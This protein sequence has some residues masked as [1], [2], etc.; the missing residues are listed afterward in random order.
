MS[1]PIDTPA[2]IKTCREIL[3][4]EKAGGMW[5][6]NSSLLEGAIDRLEEMYKEKYPAEPSE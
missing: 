1:G 5:W 4:E 6:I 2:L 3:A